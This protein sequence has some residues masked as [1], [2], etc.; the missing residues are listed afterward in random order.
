[1][2][3]AGRRSRKSRRGEEEKT[4]GR[5]REDGG[6]RMGRGR[7]EEK[8]SK[9]GMGVLKEGGVKEVRRSRGSLGR[10]CEEEGGR[11]RGGAPAS[12]RPPP[13]SHSSAA[14][15]ALILD[16]GMKGQSPLP[17]LAELGLLTLPG[18]RAKQKQKSKGKIVERK[19]IYLQK[20][21][22]NLLCSPVTLSLWERSSR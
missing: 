13:P 12:H 1:M 7:E 4:E 10:Q 22:F 14:S 6:T 20:M 9:G 16:T 3:G 8:E 11:K 21:S 5:G 2:K 17:S 15:V 19:S 18:Q